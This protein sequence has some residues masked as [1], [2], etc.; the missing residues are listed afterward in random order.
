M[1]EPMPVA[2]ADQKY[3][4][5]QRSDRAG[6]TPT[7]HHSVSVVDTSSILDHVPV[8]R[9]EAVPEGFFDW[10]IG[11]TEANDVVVLATHESWE[12]PH[13]WNWLVEQHAHW[14]RDKF[15]GEPV[16]LGGIE[17]RV[18][19]PADEGHIVKWVPAPPPPPPEEEGAARSGGHH[20][21]TKRDEEPRHTRRK[22]D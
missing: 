9:T 5:D 11:L 6:E 15:P 3:Q 13:W 2:A 7:Q 4:P 17:M 16:E 22:E 1:E 18:A 14:H 19:E 20:S 10:L 12:M 8:E 21:G